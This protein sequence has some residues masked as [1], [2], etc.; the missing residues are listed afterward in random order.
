[1]NYRDLFI[2]KEYRSNVD[3][4]VKDF[5][6]PT[7]SVTKYYDR[8]VGF[9]SSSSLA[10]IATGVAS[11]AEKGGKIR[12]V[13]SPRLS[14]EDIEAIK[15]GYKKR[16]KVICEYI[17]NELKK[18]I[19][20]YEKK[21]LNLLANLIA[22][23]ILDI[24]IAIV[25]GN[26]TIGMYHEKMGLLYDDNSNIIAFSGSMNETFMAYNINYESIDVY[27]NWESQD[28]MERVQTKQE[29]FYRIWNNT[30][31]KII[32]V[33]FPDLKD[34]IISRYKESNVDYKSVNK[35]FAVSKVSEPFFEYK[36]NQPKRPDFLK[37]LRDY[38]ELAI[39]NWKQNN[40]R[41]I[42]VMATGTG[43]TYTGLAAS[44]E[45]YDHL[46]GRLA[47]FIVCPQQ[48]L[49]NQWVEDL[50]AFNIKPII[51]HSGSIQKDYKKR[52][53]KAIL[54]YRLKIS[55]FFCFICT[56][57]TFS[58][59]YVQDE[60]KKLKDNTFL[61]VDEA[62]NFGAEHIRETLE[63]DYDFRLALSATFDRHNDEEGTHALET[64]FGNKCIEYDIEEAI[65]NG[66]LTKYYYYPIAIN[67]TEG[68]LKEYIKLTK[69]I[70]KC[71]Q[72]DLFGRTKLSKGGE[73]I[74]QERARLVAAAKNKSCALLEKME[75][76]KMDYN[77]LVYCG[78]A[79]LFDDEY[80][81]QSDTRQIDEITYLLGKRLGMKVAQFTSNESAEKREQIIRNFEEA[82][83]LQA[84]VAIKC[85]DEGVNIPSVQTAFILASTTNPKEYIQRR[86]RV[87]RTFKGKDYA[88]IYD[89]ITLPRPLEEINYTTSDELQGDLNLIK[90]ELNRV[91]E[92]KRISCNPYDSDKLI[93]ELIE[94]YNLVDYYEEGEENG[95]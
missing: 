83:E 50:K 3:N 9:F 88:K 16:E 38:Q 63:F 14:Q 74:A 81:T 13:A 87:L 73:M 76:Y 42:F 55:D 85:L 2:K 65:R 44:V 22:D 62:H 90:N 58:T 49:V 56:N 25:T 1:M 11:L 6:L 8:A 12:I 24:K 40:H 27:C 17:D 67:L 51:G 75:E 52:L 79:R 20:E 28:S 61:L 19:N 41:G 86:G 54:N 77:I 5:Y 34:K 70:S 80:E 48:H 23:E 64:F 4:I 36:M 46:N 30:E 84:L 78:A 39:E 15:F 82:T 10:E 31:E 29:A 47:L 94:G 68:E 26:S 45:L 7:L 43:K 93:E 66:M 89:F 57:A 60:I 59:E 95:N 18:P 33:D 32:T 53:H 37:Q 35:S 21:Q 71:L 91:I 69:K 72:K 92:F